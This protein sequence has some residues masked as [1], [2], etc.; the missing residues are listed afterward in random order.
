MP[1]IAPKERVNITYKPATGGQGEEVELPLKILMIGDYTGREDDT[2]VDERKPVNIN[3]DNFNEVMKEQKLEISINVAD[4]LSENAEEDA[5]LPVN[6]KFQSIDD[7]SPESIVQQVPEMRKL[8]ELRTAL[9]ALKGPLG[10]F[11]AFKK[12]LQGLLDDDQSRE[13]LLKEIGGGSD[14]GES[15]DNEG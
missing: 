5:E 6:L 15:S 11:P 13:A 1:T 3:P 12:R 14:D 9:T 2:P 8:M 10:N 4:K 7:F